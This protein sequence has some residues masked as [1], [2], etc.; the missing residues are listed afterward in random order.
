MET[1]MLKALGFAA[2]AAV[3]ALLLYATG[4]SDGRPIWYL[5]D[6]ATNPLRDY[7]VKYDAEKRANFAH[8]ANELLPCRDLSKYGPEVRPGVYAVDLAEV[9]GH[10]H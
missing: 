2:G 10:K 1:A 9:L 5:K 7:V 3:L 8:C 4:M 6:M